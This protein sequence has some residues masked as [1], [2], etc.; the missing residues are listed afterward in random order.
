[1]SRLT[2]G[3]EDSKLYFTGCDRGVF[4]P[5]AGPGIPWNG[6][7]SVT[8][9]DNSAVE[10]G[11]LDGIKLFQKPTPGSFEGLIKA[12]TYPD[13]FS[14]YNGVDNGFVAQ[15][16]RL[17]FGLS[18]RTL[19]GNDLGYQIH[20]IYGVRVAPT[21]SEYSSIDDEVEPT[22]FEWPIS[23]T[24][25][26]FPG[27]GPFSHVVIDSTIAT[28]G[29]LSELE[30]L[31]YGSTGVDPQLP[32]LQDIIDIFEENSILKITDHGDGTWTAEAPGSIIQMLDA[33]TFE[34][35]WPSAVYIDSET[36]TISSL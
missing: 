2:W 36:Y 13:E 10:S 8:S 32:P 24:P 1:M 21:Q 18:Y 26:K 23:T 25:I 19:I 16:S 7:V 11:Y 15:Q 4:Y 20:L 17:N 14:D 6:L 33:T 22:L 29:A 35:T 3:D 27:V 5:A 28:P 12:F 30:D 31:I 34:I 9:R